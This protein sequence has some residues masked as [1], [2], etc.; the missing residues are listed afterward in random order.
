MDGQG[1]SDIH[2]GHLRLPAPRAE[3]A[4][5]L[6][7]RWPSVGTPILARRYDKK[8]MSSLGGT[9]S[10]VGQ[11]RTLTLAGYASAMGRKPT[12]MRERF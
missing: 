12:L 9:T 11:Q 4:A 1:Q 8:R 6:A 10:A 5:P 3:V 7:R 2:A